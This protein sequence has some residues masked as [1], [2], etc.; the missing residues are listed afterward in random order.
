MYM[1]EIDMVLDYII[2]YQMTDCREWY[3]GGYPQFHYAE[4]PLQY[5]HYYYLSLHG[6][7]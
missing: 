2:S 4:V 1:S 3:S 6:F 5:L 7:A